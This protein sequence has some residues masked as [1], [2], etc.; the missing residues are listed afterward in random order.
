MRCTD[1]LHLMD[2]VRISN[3]WLVDHGGTRVLV[4]T[5]HA[6][7]RRALLRGLAAAGVRGP[8][9][10]AGIVLT[11]RHSDHAGSAAFLAERFDV[12]VLA[13]ERDAAVLA[14]LE[15]P[16]RLRRGVAA[17]PHEVLCEVEDRF[18]AVCRRVEGLGLGTW[19]WGFH[20]F[21][22]FGHTEGSVM[23]WHEPTGVLFAGDA[24]LT[25]IPPLRWPR[26]L[27]LAEAAYSYDVQGCH[28]HVR[29]FMA[30]PPPLRGLAGGHGPYLGTEQTAE[31]V[32]WVR[33]TSRAC[34]P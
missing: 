14:G 1:D 34:S 30:D 13:H 33:S 26:R 22:A 28:E 25:G 15:R 16:A 21:P 32:R 27:A 23:L 7:E 10:L 20:A 11:H 31:A 4:D 12:P 6:L 29:T 17:M 9:D 18:P 3:T 24:V 8:G 5:G 19:R 2:R